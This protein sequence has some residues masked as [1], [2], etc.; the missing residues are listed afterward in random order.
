MLLGRNFYFLVGYLV[1]TAHYLVVT[2]G[3]CSLPGGYDGY[4]WLLLVLGQSNGS[5]ENIFAVY[6]KVYECDDLLMNPMT[7]VKIT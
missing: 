4:W 1:V 7:L 5:G 3:Y 6:G 2:A